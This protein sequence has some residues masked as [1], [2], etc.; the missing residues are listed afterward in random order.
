LTRYLIRRFLTSL[1]VL[2]GVSVLVFSMI[3]MVPGDPVEVMMHES[4]A[5][6]NAIEA[7]RRSLGLDRPLPEQYLIWLIGNDLFRGGQ[8]GEED[9][10]PIRKGILRGDLGR[11]IFKR[12]AVTAIIAEKF[13]STLKL[14]LVALGFAAIV[15]I[16]VG[17]VA[18]VKRETI[19]DYS[20]TFAA[21]A[22]VSIPT[23]WL[24]L[25]L[26]FVFG[27]RLGWIRPFIGDRGLITLIL[28]A[29][30][31]ATP[32]IAITARLTRSSMLDVLGEN[33][34]TTARSKGLPES[35]VL[36]VHALRNG[37]IPIITILGLQFGFLLG[38][39]VIVESVFAYPGL[40]REVVVAIVNR[41]FPVVQGITLFSAAIFVFINFIVD[42]VYTFVDPRIRY[43]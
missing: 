23:F 27:V 10:R 7:M 34:I 26:M 22:G 41:D 15:G 33:Y 18:A 6:Q 30:T 14:T 3:H 43:D 32:T 24:G 19:Y 9:S 42:V 36:A 5:S 12:V 1:L 4:V 37:L 2:F 13:P 25:M 29:F 40:G 38:G 39:A 11:S 20:A 28:P 21:L 8:D 31:L 35:R 16:V 17:V